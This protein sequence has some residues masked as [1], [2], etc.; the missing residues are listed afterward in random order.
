MAIGNR[1]DISVELALE[2]ERFKRELQESVGI[3]ERSLGGLTTVAGGAAKALAAI[4][5]GLAVGQLGSFVS[6]GIKAAEQMGKL[7]QRAGVTTEAFSKLA[8]AAELADIGNEQLQ[9]SLTI[10]GRKADEAARGGETSAKAFERLGV[11][12]R[13][14]DGT[15]RSVDELFLDVAESIS[16]LPDGAEKSARAL[17]LFGRGGA[18]LIPLL[19]EG[20]RG[21][22]SFA[23]E[24]ERVGVV[25]S[26]QTAQRA[27]EFG[28]I[29]DRLGISVRA[30]GIQMGTDL[31]GPLTDV[32]QAFADGYEQGGLYDGVLQSL[33]QSFGALFD[34]FGTRDLEDMR[35]ELDTLVERLQ[36]LQG[37]GVLGAIDKA[38]N[39]ALG[40]D[41]TA[42]I[43]KVRQQ[44]NS[45]NDEIIAI[46]KESE[47]EAEVRRAPAAQ[48]A[49][50]TVLEDEGAATAAA[51]A[52][53]TERERVLKAQE[54]ALSNLRKQLEL[55]GENNELAKV[56]ADIRFGTARQFDQA[57]QAELRA[58]ADKVDRLNEEA[59]VHEYLLKLEQERREEAAKTTEA[60][61]Q[62]RAKVIES[63]RT[64]EEQ[65]S[66]EVRNLIE[67]GIGGEDLQRGI[68]Q[69]RESLEAARDKTKETTDAARELGIAF[70][71]AFSEAV[72]EADSFGDVL[73]GLGQDILQ[74]GITK[75][76]TEPLSGLFE[77]AL[78]GVLKSGGGGGGI[79][80]FFRGLFGN[81]NGGLYRVGGAGTAER[82][83]MLTAQPG[84]SIAVGRFGESGGGNTVVN[85]VNPPAQPS[86][87]ETVIDGE[88]RIDV[89]FQ[90]S[91]GRSMSRGDLSA[92][93]LRPP[94]AS[95]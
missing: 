18:Q 81:A 48:R 75:T 33:S 40:K 31:L 10:L 7:A 47:R 78:G 88:K 35:A 67:L 85:I 32:A 61:A 9:A 45:L 54:S 5:G 2:N 13:N 68:D 62:E 92:A 43:E 26:D 8:F 39:D 12:I 80:D 1:P 60:L 46:Q 57:T 41:R 55:Q 14:S 51:K 93:G 29:L 6:D 69:A 53:Q 20:R 94:L 71:S 27:D 87:R 63:L 50:G 3:A 16:R 42:E 28:D 84:E 66:A 44:I 56:E 19:N 30:V 4:G 36:Y 74:I 83:V 25:I 21:L 90:S 58:L 11:S 49:A 59:E 76:V 70:T 64:P 22:E 82:P 77:D 73:K 72:I 34:R 91:L 38:F 24:A 95:R 37:D 65:Y 17:A 89:V 52:A 23:E 86:V 79:G 15:L